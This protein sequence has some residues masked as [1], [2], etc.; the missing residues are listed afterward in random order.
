MSNQEVV[1]GQ[2]EEERNDISDQQEAEH[3]VYPGQTKLVLHRSDLSLEQVA[4]L[5]QFVKTFHLNLNISANDNAKSG[6][7][8]N[9]KHNPGVLVTITQFWF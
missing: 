4:V 6:F 9:A 7:S 5:Q 2:T 8:L 3:P 1:V